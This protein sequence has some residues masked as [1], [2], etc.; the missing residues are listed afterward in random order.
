MR[1]QTISAAR[2]TLCTSFA[3]D[4]SSIVVD[5]VVVEGGFGGWEV[6]VAILAGI[7]IA[8]MIETVPEYLDLRKGLVNEES[9]CDA[10]QFKLFRS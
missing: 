2:E 4:S 6:G 7:S 8:L 5:L 9:C 10:A 3:R 1:G